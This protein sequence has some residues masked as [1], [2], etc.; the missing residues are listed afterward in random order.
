MEAAV[1]VEPGER[2]GHRLDLGARLARAGGVHDLRERVADGAAEDAR[3]Q[4]RRRVTRVAVTRPTIVPSSARMGA[5]AASQVPHRST[6]TTLASR[7]APGERLE[8][9]VVAELN[10]AGRDRPAVVIVV[11]DDVMQR[12]SSTGAPVTMDCTSRVSEPRLAQEQQDAPVLGTRPRPRAGAAPGGR[13]RRC[14]PRP[15]RRRPAGRR[16]A[17]SCGRSTRRN[18]ATRSGSNWVPAQLAAARRRTRSYVS[19]GR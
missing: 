9:E 4:R 11:V 19:A 10:V 17:P 3:R 7:A 8:L 1:V 5:A 12:S 14:A 2:V 15:R 18:A 6:V 16:A 13:R